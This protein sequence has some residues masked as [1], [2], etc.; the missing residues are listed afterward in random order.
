MIQKWWYVVD[1]WGFVYFRKQSLTQAK[2]ILRFC[3]QS[4]YKFF[5]VSSERFIELG[6]NIDG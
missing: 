1:R 3:V 5:L 6:G 4:G 2:E